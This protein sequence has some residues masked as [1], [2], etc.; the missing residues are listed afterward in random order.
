MQRL[1]LKNHFLRSSY[2]STLLTKNTLIRNDLR[3]LTTTQ[4]CHDNK[5]NN[6]WNPVVRQRNADLGRHVFE[7]YAVRTLIDQHPDLNAGE[8]HDITQGT[9]FSFI[10]PDYC[11]YFFASI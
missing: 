3:N 5:N 6:K 1:R 10:E 2:S 9:C 7:A 11:F 4:H 8:I